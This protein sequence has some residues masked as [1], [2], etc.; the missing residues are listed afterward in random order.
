MVAIYLIRHGDYIEGK[1]TAKRTSLIEHLKKT[2]GPLSALGRAQGRALGQALELELAG[3]SV[4]FWS[5]SLLRAQQTSAELLSYLSINPALVDYQC[6][7]WECL[8]TRPV[9]ISPVLDL[10]ETRDF[11]VSRQRAN[12]TWRAICEFVQTK[13]TTLVVVC[14][15][16]IIKQFVSELLSASPQSWQFIDIDHCGLTKVS[17]EQDQL[18]IKY[19]NRVFAPKT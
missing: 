13:S 1:A 19:I 4:A 12:K 17:L 11:E 8:P 18:Y 5:S 2:D 7:L 9:A 14:H 6:A 15:G 16:N 10:I 3:K